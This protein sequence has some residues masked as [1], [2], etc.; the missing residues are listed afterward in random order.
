VNRSHEHVPADIEQAVDAAGIPLEDV[1]APVADV[2]AAAADCVAHL[3]VRRALVKRH[4]AVLTKGERAG[5]AHP[6]PAG[7]R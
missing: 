4:Q 3:T 6:A 2:L 5:T 7:K 1:E